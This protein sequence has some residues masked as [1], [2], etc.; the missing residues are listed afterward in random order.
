MRPIHLL[1]SAALVASA[2][3]G[4]A[5]SDRDT[6]GAPE[7]APPPIVVLETSRG[8]I[9]IEL[10]PDDAPQTVR[11][12]LAHLRASFYDGL[13]FHRV[14]PGFVIQ[15][16]QVTEDFS[17]R[18][19][20]V[21]PIENEADNGLKNLR[22]TVAMARTSDPH[23]AT[24]EFFINLADNAMLDFRERT[25]QGWGY[26]VFGKVVDGMAVVDTVAAGET[27]RR[28][29]HASFPVSPVVIRRAYVQAP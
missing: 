4:E 19:S 6:N 11:N 17:R 24:S 21:F 15:A 25:A 5:E 23:S 22:G 18:R 2:A 14:M 3:C 10:Y 29:E 13:V 7:A 9:T 26:T 1:T 27:R 20:S 8:D 12:F 16:G 28:G